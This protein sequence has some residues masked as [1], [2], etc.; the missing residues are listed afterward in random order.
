MANT[1]T[2]I[3]AQTLASSAASVTFSSIPATYTDLFIKF[4]ARSDRAAQSDDLA[5]NFNS[6]TAT[7]Y[8]QTDVYGGAGGVTGSSRNSNGTVL[9]VKRCVTGSTSTANTFG[10]SEFY[11]PSYTVAQSKPASNFGVAENNSATDNII[12][13]SAL[14]WRNTAAVTSIAISPANG[15]NFVTGSSFYLYG[16]KNS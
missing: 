2:L 3:E 15:T 8:S 11:M 10:N 16:I 6:D 13:A 12:D 5:V 7:N 4:A 9:F 1:Y 14:L